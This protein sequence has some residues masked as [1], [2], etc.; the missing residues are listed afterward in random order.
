MSDKDEKVITFLELTNSSD[1]E[2]ALLLLE[3]NDWNLENSVNNYFLIH[4]D[5]NKQAASSSS[6]SKSSPINSGEG[7][8]VYYDDQDN[9]R[10]PMT[11]YTD[12]MI[13]SNDVYDQFTGR[14]IPANRRRPQHQQRNNPFET[15]RNFQAEVKVP[16]PTAP[17]R[18][19]TQLAE[20]FKPPLDILSFGSFDTVKKMAE[21]K[22]AF[23]LVNIQD[24]TEFDCQKLNRDT[25]SHTGLKSYISNHFVFW[26][27][28]KDSNEGAYFVKIYPVQQ[29]PYIGIIDPR[30]GRN[31]INTQGKFI[32]SDQAYSFLQKFVTSK[33]Q[34][35]DETDSKDVKRQKRHTTEEEELEK[36][37][38][39]SLQGATNQNKQDDQ[40]E[41]DEQ[42]QQDEQ[43]EQ[44][45]QEEQ[46]EQEELQE[47]EDL[48]MYEKEI[49]VPPPNATPIVDETIGKVGDCVIQVRLPSGEVLKGN[50]QSTDTVQ[51]IY[52]FVTVKSGIKN[53]VL[54]TP[55]PRVELTGE[56]IS[57][58]LQQNDLVPRAI[59][60]V[61]D[62]P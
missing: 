24:V 32:D 9:V 26:Q 51:K 46:D 33:E 48:S 53:F 42:D 29:Y 34:P 20:L 44:E 38:Q 47:D 4:E 10:A 27:V 6:P 50:F 17:T 19:Q 30:T 59:L 12:T 39:L 7:G 58:T 49:V 5:D 60:T 3:Q 1:P 35:L 52:Y 16:S 15:F 55:F 40:D 43:D 61:K 23:L 37:I 57:K 41:Q 8:N 45:E 22:K 62:T 36:A 18:K 13:D 2:E 56:L 54:M 11:A 28:S 31:M 14:A 21:Q 25:W